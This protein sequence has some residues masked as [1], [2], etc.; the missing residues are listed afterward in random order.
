MPNLDLVKIAIIVVLVALVVVLVSSLVGLDIAGPQ[1]K[2]AWDGLNEDFYQTT[3]A[4]YPSYM[5]VTT[6]ILP[7]LGIPVAGILAKTAIGAVVAIGVVL[8]IKLIIRV[9]GS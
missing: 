9:L 4:T 6:E 7:A 8:L 2:E 3:G 5:A 1:G